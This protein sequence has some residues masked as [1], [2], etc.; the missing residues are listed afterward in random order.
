M[1]TH[2]LMCLKTGKQGLISAYCFHSIHWNKLVHVSHV[3]FLSARLQLFA[4]V[5]AYRRDTHASTHIHNSVSLTQKHNA[6]PYECHS[7]NNCA[8]AFRQ[9]RECRLSCFGYS[10]YYEVKHRACVR[11]LVPV[12]LWDG[13]RVSLCYFFLQHCDQHTL[14]MWNWASKPALHFC[15]AKGITQELDFFWIRYEYLYFWVH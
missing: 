15:I 1:S 13:V 8:A 2:P 12:A 10:T 7:S 14:W 4:C 11:A 9:K 3:P 6:L 5:M